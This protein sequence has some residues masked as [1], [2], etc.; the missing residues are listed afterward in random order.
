MK[1][2]LIFIVLCLPVLCFSQDAAKKYQ[3]GIKAAPNLGW[4]SPDTRGYSSEGTK[5]GFGWGFM[6]DIN[7]IDN[8]YFGMGFNL[9]YHNSSLSYNT[10]YPIT[11][12]NGSDSLFNG[13]L[14]RDLR[15]QY[16][17]VPLLFK[18]KTN[19]FKE[20]RFLGQ[21]GF[22][23]SFNIKARAHDV[24]Y[25]EGAKAIAGDMDV[26]DDIAFAKE[27]LLIG[28]G[29]EYSIDKSTFLVFSLN[30]NNGFTDVF[31]GK[32]PLTGDEQNATASYLELSLGIIF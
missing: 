11:Q 21:I 9:N 22:V 19:R 29:F 1:K 3:F 13:K 2:L 23:T 7:I 6:A 10:L 32:N 4:I 12:I 31:R 14:I 18:M 5:L 17:E 8:Y 24:F 27:A 25:Q 20:Y 26:F 16:I 30:Y 28:G 15:L